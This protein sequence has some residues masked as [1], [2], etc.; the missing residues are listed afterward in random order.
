MLLIIIPYQNKSDC[1]IYMYKNTVNFIYYTNLIWLNYI[2]E[3]PQN[4]NGLYY[5]DRFKA[6]T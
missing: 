6:F 3:H 1:S 4:K 5:L 2:V